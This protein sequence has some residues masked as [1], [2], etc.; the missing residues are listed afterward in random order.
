MSPNA[1]WPAAAPIDTDRLVLQPLRVQHAAEMVSVLGDRALYTFTGG[2]PPALP[3]LE[4]R[5]A[6]QAAGRSPDGAAGWLNWVIRHRRLDVLV[7]TVQATVTRESVAMS[8]AIAWTVA[9][10]HQRHGYA[11]EAAAA[12]TQWLRR[13]GVVTFM[14][15]IRP[16]HEASI[17]VARRLGLVATGLIVDGEMR[18]AS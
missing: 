12:M 4:A 3:E 16:E 9:L 15:H 10:A 11:T 8:A 17:G 5:F 13:Q 2:E 18:W 14:A 7:G 6:R 1:E